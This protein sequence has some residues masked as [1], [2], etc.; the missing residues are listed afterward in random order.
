M[1]QYIKEGKLKFE[2]VLTP[3]QIGPASIDLKLSNVFKIFKPERY[4]NLDVKKGIPDDYMEK[5]VIKDHEPFILHPHMFALAA[6][7]ERIT[8]PADLSVKVEGK[9]TLARMGLL[10]HTA[11]FVDPGFEG[12]ITLELS[13]QS[14]LPIAIYP[15]MYVCQINCQMLSSPAERPYN[16][17][18][19]SLYSNK[20]AEPG[21]ANTANL[22]EKSSQ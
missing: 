17:R 20:V 2:P 22:F 18:K 5:V 4:L 9:S 16:I 15:G 11:G 13:N 8:V 3:D 10:V 19:K 7:K 14:N 12:V 21:T 6:T 1:K